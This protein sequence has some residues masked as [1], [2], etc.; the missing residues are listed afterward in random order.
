M[1]CPLE[2]RLLLACWD[3]FCGKCQLAFGGV[4]LLIQTFIYFL[5][6]GNPSIILNN[7]GLINNALLIFLYRLHSSKSFLAYTLFY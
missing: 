3:Y 1:Q 7:R 4:A 2:G 5:S 6:E